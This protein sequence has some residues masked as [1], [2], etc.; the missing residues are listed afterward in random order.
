MEPQK[1]LSGRWRDV[2]ILGSP[3]LVPLF[4]PELSKVIWVTNR[5]AKIEV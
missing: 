4:V 5:R 3:L 1:S 2:T